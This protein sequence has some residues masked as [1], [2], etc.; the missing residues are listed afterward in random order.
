MKINDYAFDP[1]TVYDDMVKH[2]NLNNTPTYDDTP[3]WLWTGS[4]GT[5]GY[6]LY[7]IQGY[8]DSRLSNVHRVFFLIDHKE[9]IDGQVIRHQCDNRLCVRPSHLK[10]GTVAQNNQDMKDRG[11]N[12]TKRSLSPAQVLEIRNNTDSNTSVLSEKHGVSPSTIR[13]VLK[14]KVYKDADFKPAYRKVG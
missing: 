13:R 11:R 8:D 4:V 7:V 12:K 9:C 3:C 2:V 10:L 14:N 1:I 5:G 6:G